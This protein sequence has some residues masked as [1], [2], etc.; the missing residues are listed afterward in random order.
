MR[1]SWILLIACLIFGFGV[2]YVLLAGLSETTPAST[3]PSPPSH[4]SDIL[5]AEITPTVTTSLDAETN[6]LPVVGMPTPDFSL[7][8]INGEKV[9]LSDLRGRVVLLNFWATWCGP[10][11]SEMPILERYYNR[12]NRDQFVVLGINFDEPVSSVRAYSEALELTF[13]LL[14]DPG[15]KVQ[16]LYRIRG[17]PTSIFLD[18]DG[19]I[20]IYHIGLLNEDQLGHYLMELGI[21]V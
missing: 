12:V 15:A 14:L 18:V 1:R 7:I 19:I 20:Q 11:K 3:L 13:P 17:Y 21:D 16:Q 2:G 5:P 6:F 9:T 8:G 4:S 10:C